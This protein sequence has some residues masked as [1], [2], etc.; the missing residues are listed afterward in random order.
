[1]LLEFLV[2]DS[3]MEEMLNGL[4]PRLLSS[5]DWYRIHPFQGKQDLFSKLPSRL[6]GYKSWFPPDGRIIVLVDADREDCRQLKARLDSIAREAGFVVRSD[7]GAG[8]AFQV[9][10][11][12]AVEELEAW[13]L[14][15][16]EA[17]RAAYPNL[18]P[19]LR[20]GAKYR[21]SDA[22]RGG[23]CE[24]LE[25]VL[26]RAGYYPA[27]LPKIEVA[28]RMSAQMDPA[29]NRSHSFRVF[30]DALADMMR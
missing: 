29:R 7:A 15:D 1:M 17:L 21:D 16:V 9:L 19:K 20:R 11:R 14:G 24:A 23:T 2:E 8:N 10:N 18:P 25:R 5:S 22:I 3:S 30:W 13:F 12:I 28:R 27:G 4:L 6:R 26:K